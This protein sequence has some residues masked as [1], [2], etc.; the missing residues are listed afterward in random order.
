MNGADSS[1]GLSVEFA[2]ERKPPKIVV[3]RDVVSFAAFPTP[4]FSP[5]A[6]NGVFPGK[7]QAF[8]RGMGRG[9]SS[10]IEKGEHRA[11]KSLGGIQ[12]K[13]SVNDGLHAAKGLIVG[14]VVAE[15]QRSFFDWRVFA[16]RHGLRLRLKA[17]DF[18]EARTIRRR[19]PAFG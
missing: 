15:A 8:N 12:P 3:D 16:E 9:I 13:M 5:G 6:A 18:V 4:K 11:G 19:V 10:R 2:K 7:P 17:E 14:K 1:E